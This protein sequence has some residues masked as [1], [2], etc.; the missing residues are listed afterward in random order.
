MLRSR[1]SYEKG[2]FRTEAV[3]ELKLKNNTGHAI[4]RAYFSGV[5]SSPGRSIPWVK[6]TFN[7]SIS[8]GLEPG[9]KVTWNLTPNMFGGW[10]KAPKNRKDMILTVDV[11]RIDG[12]DGKA[13]YDAEF[14]KRDEEEL[15]DLKQRLVKLKEGLG[16]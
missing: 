13:I 7:Y 9:E 11:T 15:A 10:S 1:C 6:E 4:S 8:G 16:E 12:A 5:L 3:I 2:R 14:S